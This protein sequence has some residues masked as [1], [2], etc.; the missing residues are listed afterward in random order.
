MSLVEFALSPMDEIEPWGCPPDLRL[1]WFGLS[2]GHYFFDVGSAR[3]LEYRSEPRYVEY[4]IARVH[5]DL[6][7]ML[8]DVTDPLPAQ[9]A[10]LLRDASLGETLHE[11]E[12]VWQASA[13]GDDDVGEALE[14]LS[15]R[16]LDT[17]YLQ[18]SAGIWLWSFG[19]DVVIEWDNRDRLAEGQPVWTAEQGRLELKSADFLD[20][21]RSFHHRFVSDM[22][23]RVEE[24]SR[25]WRRREVQLDVEQLRKES[26]ERAGWLDSAL[27]RPVVERD[28]DLVARALT[29][30]MPRNSA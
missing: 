21:I 12:K 8:S 7:S 6:V 24:A 1:H 16:A 22:D 11:L 2:D 26:V 10:D 27:R 5:E 4:Q 30:F 20:E 15:R 3:L 9:V 28:W 19:D 13:T 18:P 14:V 17:L 25:D 29:R 23:H